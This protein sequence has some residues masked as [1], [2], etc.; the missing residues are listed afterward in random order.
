MLTRRKI[1]SSLAANRE[2]VRGF[3][4]KKLGV[5]GSYA[6]GQARKNSD[7]DFVVQFEKKSFDA[8]MDLKFFL[9]DLFHAKVDLVLADRIKPRLRQNILRETRYA[10]GL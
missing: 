4:V 3:G 7:M 10:E 9:E 8:Y 6:R 1:L 2:A 5:F